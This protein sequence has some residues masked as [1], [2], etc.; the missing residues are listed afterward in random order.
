MNDFPPR[1][2]SSVAPGMSYTVHAGDELVIKDMNDEEMSVV[3]KE[4]PDVLEFINAFDSF[5]LVKNTM[6]DTAQGIHQSAW[7]DV[8]EKFDK[9]PK[10]VQEQLPSIR[11]G[12][13]VIPGKH[14]H[15]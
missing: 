6:P 12:G 14:R 3:A 9:L 10:H 8:M 7:D 4:H 11:A 1:Q 5:M 15:E 13:I 2:P